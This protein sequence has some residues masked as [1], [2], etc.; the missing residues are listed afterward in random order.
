MAADS[1]GDYLKQEPSPGPKMEGDTMVV[2]IQTLKEQMRYDRKAFAVGPGMKVK[3]EFSNPD[4]MDHN[5]IFVQPGSGSQ[6]ALAAM[7][8][9]AD[10]IKKNWTPESDRIIIGSN[11]AVIFST[12]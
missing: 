5:M 2:H 6:V 8:L 4:A 11:H 10:G 9:G 7:M 1:T 12:A 3:I